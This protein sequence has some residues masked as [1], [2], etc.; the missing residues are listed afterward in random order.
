MSQQAKVKSAS[1]PRTPGTPSGASSISSAGNGPSVT[2]LPPDSSGSVTESSPPEAILAR[3]MSEETPAQTD[4]PQE[5]RPEDE[6]PASMWLGV[7]GMIALLVLAAAWSV[8]HSLFGVLLAAAGIVVLF[9]AIGLAMT[10][11]KR[12]EPPPPAE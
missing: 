11:A 8:S 6:K 12:E 7:P 5:L 2:R 10:V 3:E 9:L 4:R 1:Q